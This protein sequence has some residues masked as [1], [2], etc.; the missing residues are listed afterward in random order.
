MKPA[1]PILVACLSLG[2]G[3]ALA[4]SGSLMGP[5]SIE[6]GAAFS[7]QFGGSGQA[8]LYIS[9]P[10][11][12]IKRDVQLGGP[13]WF[14]AGSLGNAG[15][16]DVFL[17]S[18]SVSESGSMDVLPADKPADLTFIAKPSRLPVALHGAITGAVY[19]C[20]SYRNLISKPKSVSFEL[21]NPS[22][23]TQT[24]VVQTS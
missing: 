17:S 23:P 8:T 13:A 1:L 5:A 19:V 3:A 16:Y 6:A 12:L 9:G 2:G 15:H 14:P 4:Q 24:H 20:D 18:P 10:G 21:S 11:Q 22:S 7:I